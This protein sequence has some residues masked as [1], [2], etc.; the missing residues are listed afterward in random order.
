MVEQRR[1]SVPLEC[2]EWC[3]GNHGMESDPLRDVLAPFDQVASHAVELASVEVGRVGGHMESYSVEL[4]REQAHPRSEAQPR[5]F[6]VLF[7]H[8]D[9]EI[10][11]ANFADTADAIIATLQAAKARLAEIQAAEA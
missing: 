1:L 3:S 9:T 11:P 7:S 4:V 10:E 6:V 2:P 5:E 8:D